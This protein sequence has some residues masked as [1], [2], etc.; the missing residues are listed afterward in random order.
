MK[1]A[2]INQYGPASELH[3]ADVPKPEPDTHEVLIRVHATCVNPFETHQRAGDMKLMMSSDFP[4]I[5][6]ADVAGVVEAVGL[7]ITDFQPGDRVVATLGMSGG[8]YAEYAVAKETNLVKLPDTITFEQAAAMPVAAGTALQA[9]R[10][11]GHLRPMDRVLINGAAGGVGHYAVQLAK[12]LGATVTAVC[13][14][15]AVTMVKELGADRVINYRE[16]DFTKE[17]ETYDLV[18]DAVA[19]SSFDECHAILTP[20]GTYVTTRPSPKGVLE[21]VTS[22]FADQKADFILF[23]FT[24]TDMNWMLKHTAEGRLKSVIQ[25]TY[26]LAEIAQAHTEREAGH[27][28]GKLV[29]TID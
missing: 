2:I 5:L 20:T 22:L 1:A 21:K 13:G 26:P 8:A 18:F 12:I 7:M 15:D 9:M 19:K 24:Q 4:K 23:S 27:V 25:H 11:K 14:P 3:V 29:V 28:K 6:G 16:I 17:D 10:D